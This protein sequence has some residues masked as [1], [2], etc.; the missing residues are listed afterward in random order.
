MSLSISVS[1]YLEDDVPFMSQIGTAESCAEAEDLNFASSL[2][3]STFI[4]IGVTRRGFFFL[5][6]A[7][8]HQWPTL[9]HAA[10]TRAITVLSLV[11]LLFQSRN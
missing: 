11:I 9:R 3:I 6:C 7:V 4:I 10:T 1:T 5:R 2:L 8:E